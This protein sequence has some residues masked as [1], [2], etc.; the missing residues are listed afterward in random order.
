MTI[1]LKAFVSFAVLGRRFWAPLLLLPLISSG[2]SAT[3]QFSGWYYTSIT[4]PFAGESALVAA[5]I[6]YDTLWTSPAQGD[7]LASAAGMHESIRPVAGRFVPLALMGV[8]CFW[9]HNMIGHG[10]LVVNQA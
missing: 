1:L 6:L 4:G 8:R 7:P 5:G 9:P 10:G 3:I 2:A